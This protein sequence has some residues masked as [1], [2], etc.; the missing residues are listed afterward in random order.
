[1]KT[2]RFFVISILMITG[3]YTYAQP[4]TT[5]SSADTSDYP[6]WIEMMQDESV[7]FYDVQRAFETYWKDRPITKGSG[8]KPFKRWEYMMRSGKINPDGSRKPAA[9]NWNQYFNYYAS[10]SAQSIAGNWK[11]IGPVTFT[12]LGYKG[13]GRVN[14]V[15]FH[16]G[17]PN[18]FYIGAPSGGVWKTTDGGNSWGSTTDNLPTLGVSSIIVNHANADIVYIGTGDRDAGDAP[19]LGVMRST[20]AGATWELW[21]TGMGDKT[22]GRM[23]Q[24]PTNANI[25]FAATN[26]G[27]YKTI[28]AGTNWSQVQSGN[29]KDILFKPGNP[30]VLYAVSSATFYRSTNGGDNF[31]IVS[32]GLEGGQRAV[33]AVTPANPEYVYLLASASDNGFKGLYKSTNGGTSFV[34]QSS[35]PNIMDWSCTGSGSG[36]QAWYDLEIAADPINPELIF[37]GGVNVWKSMNGGVTWQITGH[38]YGGCNVAEVHADQHVFEYNPLNNKLYVGNDGGIYSTANQGATFTEH[39]NGLVISQIYKIGQNRN[40]STNLIIGTQD[41]GTSSIIS[42]V[43]QDTHGG[44]GMECIIDHLNP[45]YS[46]A[47][48]YYGEI[49]RHFNN[50]GDYTIAKMGSFGITE[51]GDWVTPY[52]LHETDGNKMFIG[53]KNIW[54]GSN[55][56]S[57]PSWTKISNSLAGSNSSN[58]RVVEQSPVNTNILYFARYDKKLFRSDNVMDATPTWVNLSAALPSTSTTPSA[59]EAHPFNANIIYMAQNGVVYKS[60]D[61]G[62]TWTNFSGTLP[63]VEYTSIAC[64]KNSNDGVYVA[65]DIGV[66]YRD[67]SMSDWI[68]FS[69][70][71]PV[72]ASIREIEIYYHPTNNEYDLVRAGT[73]GRGTWSSKVYRN[74]PVV[75]FTSDVVTVPV[76]GNVN[77][78]DLSGGIPS[79]WLWTFEGGSPA[80]S[81]EKNPVVAYNSAGVWDVSLTV[82]NSYGSSS[83][84]ITDYITSSG[85]ILPQV[86]FYSDKPA[87]CSGSIVRLYDTTLYNPSSWNWEFTP[88]TVNFLE[89]TSATSQN[90]V[91]TMSSNMPYTVKLTA[92]NAN[93]SASVTKQEFVAMGGFKI[94]FEEGF[95]EGFGT[96]GWE[97]LNPDFLVT[98]EMADVQGNGSE[99]AARMPFITYNRMNER[100]GLISP[101]VNLSGLT[102]VYMD[103]KHAYVQR[104]AQKDSLIIYVSDNCGNSWNRVYANGPDGNGIFETAPNSDVSFVPATPED[105]C[106]AG[107][108]ADCITVDLSPWA[109]TPDVRIKF[110]SFNR[111]GNNLYI[112]D[113]VIRNSPVGIIA[114][115]NQSNINIH[116]N[117]SDGT[118]NLR[119]ELDGEARLFV[120][121]MQGKTVYSEVLHGNGSLLHTINLKSLNAG[122]YMLRLETDKG[123]TFVKLMIR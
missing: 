11:S 98:W 79:A 77:F 37:T 99:K 19:G 56:R 60:T 49:V 44:D 92:T 86:G 76:S 90:P 97:I 91:V 32:A 115:A 10:K 42:N 9:Y 70:G 30:S 105:W 46:Y 64:Y 87:Y 110:E 112:D 13:L 59:L 66:F 52:V 82:T 88:N 34:K 29:F 40:D 12:S 5:I 53:Y 102:H 25:L 72:D 95:E 51:E 104:Y 81:T 54:R 117:P 118:F 121:D 14:A 94:P 50:G 85:S 2:I 65:S 16:P 93:G 101:P 100:D 120:N 27:I 23:I 36:G 75:D 57:T 1:M 116:P 123:N 17:D 33:I 103:F 4:G 106:G 119:M 73:Y 83:K 3:L 107:Y 22:V 74:T 18:T 43:W 20:N 45:A 71:L 96:K 108:G 15:A 47:S 7:N 21:N 24:H 31:S 41:N 89:G 8:F 111:F 78:Q 122:I 39:T 6:Y 114:P 61:K 84:T 69:S 113:I 28:N 26:G 68:P 63:V 62:E 80:T 55:I 67:A 58:I 48:L 38:W 35:T 109:G